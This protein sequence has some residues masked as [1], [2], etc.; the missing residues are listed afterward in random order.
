MPGFLSQGKGLPLLLNPE[1]LGINKGQRVP[2]RYRYLMT[3]R[4]LSTPL[5]LS[6]FY[7]FFG[8]GIYL[9]EWP[10]ATPNPFLLYPSYH[11]FQDNPFQDGCR[12]VRQE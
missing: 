12:N 4:F 11:S 3:P 6:K 5:S 2:D 10:I 8:G 7:V 1:Y 9:T